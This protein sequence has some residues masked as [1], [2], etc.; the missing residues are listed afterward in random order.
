VAGRRPLA[1]N[2]AGAHFLRD[3]ALIAQL[4]RGCGARDGR[5]ILDL[6]AGGGAITTALAATGA[7]V[8]AV[9]HDPRL[10][11]RLRRRFDADPRIRVV[12]ADLR[13]VPLPRREFLVVASPPFSLTTALCRRLLGDPA[14]P[15]AG[16]ELI[17]QRGAARWLASP[18][19]R[20]AET[21]WWAARYE[22]RLARTVSPASFVPP[23]RVDAARLTIKPRPITQH[24]AAQ[25]RLRAL[26]RAAYRAP[27]VRAQALLDGRGGGGGRQSRRLLLAAA[28]DPS[29]LAA[30]LTADQWH[31]LAMGLVGRTRRLP[32]LAS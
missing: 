13:T 30:Q 10:A 27:N 29:A 23:P 26:L 20:D 17:L 1:P 19:P 24:P 31:R 11:A 9:E 8:I 15:L 25:S 5:L 3:R 12:Q 4:V 16:A 7:R 6:G 28:I 22:L 21:A 14:V 18:R 32:R 2:P